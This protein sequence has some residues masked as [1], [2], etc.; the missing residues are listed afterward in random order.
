MSQFYVTDKETAV[1]AHDSV[2]HRIPITM[3]GTVGER[4]GIFTGPAQSV[5]E[6]TNA[7]PTRWRITILDGK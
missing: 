5:E 6:D 2:R 7:T 3:S 1:R 4:I